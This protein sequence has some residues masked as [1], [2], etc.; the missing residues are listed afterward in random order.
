MSQE[1]SNRLVNGCNL[2]KNEVYESYNPLTNLLLTSWDIQVHL[3]IVINHLLFVDSESS[4]TNHHSKFRCHTITDSFINNS[5]ENIM[6]GFRSVWSTPK[7]RRFCKKRI[8]PLFELG[9]TTNSKTCT[10]IRRS[11]QNIASSRHT[12]GHLLLI[13]VTS[14]NMQEHLCAQCSQFQ[15]SKLRTVVLS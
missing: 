7:V 3:S 6:H 12:V 13:C 4:S 5:Q 14:W 1:V 9:Q 10:L 8:H 2:R 11:R 15:S